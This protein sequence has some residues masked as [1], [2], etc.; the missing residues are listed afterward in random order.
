MSTIVYYATGSGGTTLDT[1]EGGGNPF[2]SG[3]IEVAGETGLELRRLGERL[4][5]VTY[6]KS[7]GFQV[8]ECVGEPRLRSWSI[9]DDPTRT[10]ERRS[11][12]VLVVSDYS[13]FRPGARLVGAARDERRIAVM[14]A[15]HGF[16]LDQ[17]VGPRRAELVEALASFKRR[18][19]RSDIAV[20]YSTGHGIELDG[21]VHL[22]PGDYPFRDGFTSAQLRRH[23]ISVPQMMNASA[24]KQNLVFFAGCRSH[25]RDDRVDDL[26]KFAAPAGAG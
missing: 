22:L 12:L 21:V 11:A 3:L 4:R 18:S 16:S 23:A 20:I 25:V 19:H 7:Q 13:G 1:G 8:V 24:A 6:A 17:G 10:S 14:L 2:A 5:E 26:E 15:E 9:G